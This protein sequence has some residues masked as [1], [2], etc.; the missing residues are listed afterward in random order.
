MRPSLP[1]HILSRVATSSQV[2]DR[3]ARLYGA[4][5]TPGT[6]ASTLKLTNDANGAGTAVLLL[7]A[8]A[9]GESVFLDFSQLGPVE[10]SAKIYATLAGTGAEAY[11]WYDA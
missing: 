3:P 5:L 4:L 7:S 2:V 11:L 10:F 6:A 8:P 1:L 9:N